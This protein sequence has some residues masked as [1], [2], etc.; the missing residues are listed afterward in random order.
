MSAGQEI[1]ANEILLALPQKQHKQIFSKLEFISLPVGFALNETAQPI[2]FAY[3]INSGLVS[4][5]T[6]MN[7]GRSVAVS[8]IGKEGFVGVPLLI[9]LKSSSTRTIMQAAGSAF[10]IAAKDVGEVVQGCQPLQVKLTRYAQELTMQAM[11]IAACNC[12]HEV[13]E[14]LAHRIW[15]SRFN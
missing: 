2:E 14:R 3:F 8:L 1:L 4:V 7:D 13:G 5:L 12:M 9:G 11:Q 15:R 6:V 10:R